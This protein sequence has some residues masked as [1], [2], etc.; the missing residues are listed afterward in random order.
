M[1][2]ATLKLAL[3]TVVFTM[4]TM[5]DN[6]AGRGMRDTVGNDPRIH[7]SRLLVRFRPGVTRAAKEEA[8]EAGR[9]L[10]TLEEYHAVSD[11]M[12]VEVPE[13]TVDKAVAA[14]RK[15]PNVLYAEPDCLLCVDDIPNDPDF[16]LLWGLQNTGQTVVDKPG[17]PGSDIQAVQA[18]DYWAGDPDFRIA[19]IDTGVDYTHPDL[20]ANI[21]TNE[22][23]LNGQPDVDDDGNGYIDDIHGYDFYDDDG[24]PMDESGHGTHVSGTIGGV[25][26][27]NKGVVGVNWDC[28]IVALRFLG[29]G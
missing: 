17:T 25:G 22:L 13:G 10:R 1:N 23:E 20:A 18:W 26:D 27:N 29:G 5:A 21:W 16:G 24:D 2:S 11:L 3:T 28:R 8:H 15:N 9:G 4:S 12:L 19:V 14:Y 6:T 7:P